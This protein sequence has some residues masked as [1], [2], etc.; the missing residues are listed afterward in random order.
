MRISTTR[1]WLW[2]CLASLSTA[3]FAFLSTAAFA[4]PFGY[5]DSSNAPAPYDA[6]WTASG[7][8]QR[9]GAGYGVDDGVSWSV[10]GGITFG[11]DPVTMGQWVAFK[12]DV[13][14]HNIGGHVFDPLR[15]WV[16][17]NGDQRWS[18]DEM[19]ISTQYDKA[20]DDPYWVKATPEDPHAATPYNGRQ[21][22]NGSADDWIKTSFIASVRISEALRLSET[23]LRARVTC[24]ASVGGTDWYGYSDG[25]WGWHA[26]AGDIELMGPTGYL[27]Q[28]EAE[29]Y[30]LRILP[31]VTVPEPSTLLLLFLGLLAVVGIRRKAA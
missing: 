17:W 16:D 6:A 21:W 30:L 13:L 1:A 24:D 20:T 8:W 10:D 28:G 2:A 15:A 11:H 27:H 14:S 5:G 12:F 9:L 7:D 3:A 22:L 25:Y 29:D 4:S 31:A 23:W 18:E 26:R 19:I